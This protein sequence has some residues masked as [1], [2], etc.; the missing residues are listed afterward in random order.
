MTNLNGR[1]TLKGRMERGYYDN[2]RVNEILENCKIAKDLNRALADATRREKENM[3][4]IR[5]YFENELNNDI[6]NFIE[7]R[8]FVPMAEVCKA[9]TLKDIKDEAYNQLDNMNA[10]LNIL[11]KSFETN[12]EKEEAFWLDAK[13]MPSYE[14]LVMEFKK[15][16]VPEEALSAFIP[17]VQEM[18]RSSKYQDI[19][20]NRDMAGLKD[21]GKRAMMTGAYIC[22]EQVFGTEVAAIF[23]NEMSIHSFL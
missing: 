21:F 4:E 12:C 11:Y 8:D 7:N 5:R 2:N 10:Q 19:V 9:K 3:E 14:D 13:R 17:Y 1:L 15:D 22:I 6:L 23:C 18:I 16:G 20:D